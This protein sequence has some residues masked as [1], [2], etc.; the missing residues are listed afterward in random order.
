VAFIAMEKVYFS[1]MQ[2]KVTVNRHRVLYLPGLQSQKT[3]F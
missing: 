2:L 1:C 3:L